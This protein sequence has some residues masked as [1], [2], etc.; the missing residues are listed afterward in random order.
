[1]SGV[2]SP[3]LATVEALCRFRL[4][5][6]DQGYAVELRDASP[7]LQELLVLCGLE[8]VLPLVDQGQSEE[9]EQPRGIEEEV[10]PGDSA[11]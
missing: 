7:G 2:I 9:R 8:G 4:A 1:M 11:L 10:E 5:L 6:A 3:D